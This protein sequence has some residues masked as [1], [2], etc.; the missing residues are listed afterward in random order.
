[1]S[2]AGGARSTEEILEEEIGARYSGLFVIG[3]D[4]DVY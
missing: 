3:Q 4:L 1:M 2:A